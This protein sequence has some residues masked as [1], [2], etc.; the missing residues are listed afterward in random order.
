MNLER[1]AIVEVL[2]KYCWIIG[3]VHFVLQV[4]VPTLQLSL[5]LSHRPPPP[6]PP[7]THTHWEKA[8]IRIN[9]ALLSIFSP[10][11]CYKLSHILSSLVSCCM[12]YRTFITGARVWWAN[13]PPNRL[14]LLN[15]DAT[16]K[17]CH[18][19]LSA[20]SEL[21]IYVKFEVAALGSLGE[22]MLNVLRCH[23]TY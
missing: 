14:Y 17:L 9:D 10:K 8:R 23:L 15:G 4:V 22:V 20:H 16:E 12:N 2:Q 3:L 5:S 19:W 6:P 11:C 7:H 18:A 13:S 21:R 1:C